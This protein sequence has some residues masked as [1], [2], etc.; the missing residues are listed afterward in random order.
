ME[1]KQPNRF[2]FF[3]VV[4]LGIALVHLILFFSCVP[5]T[6]ASETPDKNESPSAGSASETAS[7]AAAGAAAASSR[8]EN[9]K[10]VTK[11]RVPSGNPRFGE[12]LDFS[13][14]LHGNALDRVIPG[15]S[16]AGTAIL[17]DMNSR[18][19][20]W[21]KNC[22][23]SVPV[24]SMT[25][26]MTLLLTMEGLD[27]DP[28][29]SLDDEIV[30]TKTVMQV[31][32]TGVLWLNPGEKFTMRELVTGAAVKSANDAAEMC[33][34][35]TGGTI[36][37]FIDMMNDR[38]KEMHLGARFTTVHG[39]PDRA[40]RAPTGSALDMVLLGE[41]LLEY[42]ELMK[43]FAMQQSSIRNGQ[44]V[45]VNTNRLVNPRY[46]GVEGMKTGYT[47]QAGFCLT[48]SVQRDRRRLMGCVTGFT[49]AKER[50]RFCR[51]LIDWAYGRGESSNRSK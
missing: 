5:K 26:M 2:L 25:K 33:A 1:Q 17:V 50:D 47:K 21:E 14:A 37:H 10:E 30:I 20:I 35:L 16:G 22:R 12:A 11:L 15:A 34:E 39:L 42:P 41:R 29:R 31:P 24:A 43:M 48:F 6:P 7:G 3:V 28:S 40:G 32:R 27:R 4:F 38:A 13:A 51:K 23:K 18:R 45:F 46:P 44:T 9:P 8:E 49:S 19:V 36:D